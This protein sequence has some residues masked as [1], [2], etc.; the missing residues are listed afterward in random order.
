MKTITIHSDGGSRGNPG[1]AGIGVVVRQT[2]KQT[3]RQTD[4][5]KIS[6]FIGVATNNIAE[7]QA[8]VA[9]LLWVKENIKEDSQIECYLDSQLVV[10]QLKGNYKMKNEGLKPLYWQARSLI[11]DLGG[12][13][14]F[15]YVPREENKEADALVNEALDKE[16]TG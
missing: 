5:K 10:E 14:I 6:E 4:L 12:K 16:I 9:G 13:V 1:P 8:I 15:N 11:M 7:Y 2:D 3:N